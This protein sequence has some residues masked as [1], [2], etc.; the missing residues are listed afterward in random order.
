[1]AAALYAWL[2]TIVFGAVLMDISYSRLLGG[3]SVY[4]EQVS[5]FLLALSAV[6]IAA[7]VGAVLFSWRSLAAMIALLASVVIFLLEF[8]V[9]MFLLPL[10][11]AMEAPNAGS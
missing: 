11:N 2:N 7:G 8:I 1:M 5:D 6:T 10:L 9:P 3:G 4:A